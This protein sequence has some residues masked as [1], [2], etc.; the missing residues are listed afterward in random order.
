MRILDQLAV[1]SHSNLA[2]DTCPS[3]DNGVLPN[4]RW[5]RRRLSMSAEPCI[6]VQMATV[7]CA[8]TAACSLQPRER[9]CG[10]P[11]QAAA[12]TCTATAA[13]FGWAC[14]LKMSPMAGAA[15]ADWLF[16]VLAG[17]AEDEFMPC[18]A[19]DLFQHAHDLRGQTA[20]ACSI[21][22]ISAT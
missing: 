13:L 2:A 22:D 5:R 15:F 9:N 20:A 18:C 3:I 16:G 8:L 1:D 12:D 21:P 7:T 14:S 4:T 6:A 17:G 11:I 10:A 19:G